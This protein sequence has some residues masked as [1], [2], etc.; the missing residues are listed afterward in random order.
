VA[1]PDPLPKSTVASARLHPAC[2][3]LC[4]RE[5]GTRDRDLLMSSAL[6]YFHLGSK[7]QRES[8]MKAM[9]SLGTQHP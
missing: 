6:L 5:F 8:K 1:L 3:L 7:E 2:G 4:S 9:Q